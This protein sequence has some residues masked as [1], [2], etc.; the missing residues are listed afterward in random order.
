MVIMRWRPPRAAAI[1]ADTHTCP[2]GVKEPPGVRCGGFGE[3]ARLATGDQLIHILRL[4]NEALRDVTIPTE[5]IFPVRSLNAA[6]N[7]HLPR[8]AVLPLRHAVNEIALT[9]T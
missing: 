6:S 9:A 4:V 3:Y 2:L 1:P 7:P 5:F 8:G